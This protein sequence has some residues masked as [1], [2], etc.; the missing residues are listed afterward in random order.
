MHHNLK[1]R[2]ATFVVAL[3]I[4]FTGGM[5]SAA[6]AT[7]AEQSRVERLAEIARKVAQ[8][9]NCDRLPLLERPR[10]L[11]EFA[12]KAVK[13]GVGMGLFLFI[14]QDAMKDHGAS[15]KEFD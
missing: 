15:F 14:T 7:A 3:A 2:I 13:L 11:K 5:G 12:G 4:L 9:A 8:Y 6:Q 1:S 10:C